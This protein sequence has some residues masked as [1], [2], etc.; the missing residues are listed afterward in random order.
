MA[1]ANKYHWVLRGYIN[2]F[3]LFGPAFQTEIH[4]VQI[5]EINK[6]LYR[7]GFVAN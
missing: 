1:G 7:L 3:E 5:D 6:Y 4:A 2:K